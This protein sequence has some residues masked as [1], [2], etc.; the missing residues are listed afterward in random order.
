[1]IVTTDFRQQKIDDV[2]KEETETEI[3]EE[4]I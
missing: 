3:E 2:L 1:V 4:E